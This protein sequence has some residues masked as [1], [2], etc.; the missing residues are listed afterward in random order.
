M[1]NKD[2]IVIVANA[3]NRVRTQSSEQTITLPITEK[4]Q[5]SKFDFEELSLILHQ[6]VEGGAL[7]KVT[8]FNSSYMNIMGQRVYD[9]H[10]QI[11]VGPTFDKWIEKNQ[12]PIHKLMK[13]EKNPEEI[14]YEV[15]FTDG[16]EIL[17]NG[18]LFRKPQI[19]SKNFEVFE[20]VYQNPNRPI[21]YREVRE[22]TGLDVD[23]N[24]LV[25]SLGFKGNLRKAF[26]NFAA[27]NTIEF[28]NPVRQ[29]RLEK[30]GI[31][32]LKLQ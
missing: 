16:G 15:E 10:F 4:N 21:S 31:S 8:P 24:K 17:I 25:N 11:V 18:I 6:L 20:F 28:V 3:I 23:F 1:S 29:Q 26:F 9:Q 30:I 12:I 27:K 19:D 5:L 13:R 7:E 32:R 14:A 22:K 2:N